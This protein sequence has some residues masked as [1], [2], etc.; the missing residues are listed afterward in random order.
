MLDKINEL[1]VSSGHELLNVQGKAIK[2]RC[3][4]S[5]CLRM[6]YPRCRVIGRCNV[7]YLIS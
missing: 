1:V 5:V 6:K 7:Y 3:D 4:S 2:A